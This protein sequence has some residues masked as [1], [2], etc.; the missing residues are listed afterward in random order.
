MGWER[1]NA[2]ASTS[3]CPAQKVHRL[4]VIG[5]AHAGGRDCFRPLAQDF[6]ISLQNGTTVTCR[7]A[8]QSARMIFPTLDSSESTTG[9]RLPGGARFPDDLMCN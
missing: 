6:R 5:T 7:G 1:T 9:K 3:E 4:G 2:V 8:G